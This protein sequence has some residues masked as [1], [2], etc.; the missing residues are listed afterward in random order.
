MA[1]TFTKGIK[2]KYDVFVTDSH[3]KMSLKNQN[4]QGKNS[5]LWT[6]NFNTR[7]IF[8]QFK[9]IYIE[10]DRCYWYVFIITYY[11]DKIF[12]ILVHTIYTLL[13]H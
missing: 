4:L 8:W 13:Q 3:F 10:N 9:R 11:N 6:S 1:T 12:Y 5:L 2:L 7:W